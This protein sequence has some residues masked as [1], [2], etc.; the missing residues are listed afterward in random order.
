MK[1]CWP[2][3]GPPRRRDGRTMVSGDCGAPVAESEQLA[4]PSNPRAWAVSSCVK[5][6]VAWT[7]QRSSGGRPRTAQGSGRR[8]LDPYTYRSVSARATRLARQTRL[9]V[10]AV[11]SAILGL[12]ESS[13]HN[14]P[15]N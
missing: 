1:D 7:G 3:A 13:S 4:M 9:A 15:E 8:P 2:P 6:W 11:P 14:G 5:G 12:N 10:G